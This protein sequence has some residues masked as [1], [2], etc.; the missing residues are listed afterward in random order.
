[1]PEKKR[2]LKV[3]APSERTSR[4]RSKENKSSSKAP[5]TAN[6]KIRNK[7]VVFT[8]VLGIELN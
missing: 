4:M 5:G 3:V 8:Q 7:K 1:M 2:D 6:V